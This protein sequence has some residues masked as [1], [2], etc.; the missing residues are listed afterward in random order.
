[1]LPLPGGG[2]GGPVLVSNN[3]EVF[4]G[5]GLFYGNARPSPTRGGTSAP[6]EGEFGVYLHHLNRSGSA[7]YVW[8][9]VT[10]PNEASVRLEATGSAYTQTETGGLAIGRSPDYRVSEDFLLGTPRTRVNTSVASFRPFAVWRARVEN[11]AEVD[12]RFALESDRPVYVYVLATDT[13]DLNEAVRQSTREAR[14]DIRVSGNPPPPFGREA[15]VYANDTWDASFSVAIPDR[16]AHVGFMVNT[17]TGAG[18]SQVQAFEAIAHYD[19]SAREAVGMYGNVYDFQVELIGGSTSRRVR[20][21]FWSLATASISRYWDGVG[22]VDGTPIHVRHVPGSQNTVLA[23]VRLG[24]GE[25]R[26]VRFR[27]MV[28]GLASI[29]QALTV[30]SL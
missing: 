30:E 16:S 19:D 17:A 8:L 23:D 26:V 15:G 12:G 10:N 21:R 28:P 25:R 14:G 2:T 18:F 3:P 20:L 1:L 11:G 5:P 13:D 22:T 6:L 24:A 7:K 4:T 9:L 27:A 29:P